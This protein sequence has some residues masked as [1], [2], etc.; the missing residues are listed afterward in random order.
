[1]QT[2][3]CE[4]CYKK[5]L[6]E[7]NIGTKQRNH[8]PFCLYSKHVDEEKGDRKAECQGLM[9][10]IGLTFKK[11]GEGRIGEVMIVHLCEKC[12]KISINR[13]AADDKTSTIMG[14]FEKSLAVESDTKMRIQELN[15][16]LLGKQDEKEL[17]VQLFG[18]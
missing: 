2:F 8:C 6:T 14:V 3:T 11:E 12:G 18:N 10:P 7:G 1:M 15:I 5:V 13:I 4:H 9:K 16:V 17:E